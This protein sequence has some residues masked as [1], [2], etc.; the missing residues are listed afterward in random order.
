MNLL[1]TSTSEVLPTGY[2]VAQIFNVVETTSVIDITATTDQQIRA[3]QHHEAISSLASR[4]KLM[5][6]NA[7]AIIGIRHSTAIVQD[8]KGYSLYIT[9]VGTVVRI[10]EKAGA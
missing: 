6:L 5:S 2:E 4:V 3:Q 10:E 1:F 8:I 7:N 9:Y